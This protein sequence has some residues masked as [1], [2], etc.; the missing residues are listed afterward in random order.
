MFVKCQEY[1]VLF[2]IV[3][4]KHLRTLPYICMFFCVFF[5]FYSSNTHS[6]IFPLFKL[7]GHIIMLG[8]ILTNA[9]KT[10]LCLFGFTPQAQT[11]YSPPHSRALVQLCSL[12]L[13]G[14]KGCHRFAEKPSKSMMSFLTPTFLPPTL[15]LLTLSLCPPFPFFIYAHKSQWEGDVFNQKRKKYGSINPAFSTILM[16]SLCSSLYLSACL[17]T[18]VFRTTCVFMCLCMCVC[19]GKYW[20]ILMW[21][22][23]SAL[24]R[25]HSNI[26]I[27]LQT[28]SVGWDAAIKLHGSLMHSSY[29]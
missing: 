1:S 23:T 29:K 6:H 27:G 20:K 28:F 2:N 19:V 15:S 13:C 11:H 21:P 16:P 22:V 8:N 26:L 9:S 4:L 18:S 25:V 10:F 7:F 3:L 14:V 12:P 24:S 17:H 5:L